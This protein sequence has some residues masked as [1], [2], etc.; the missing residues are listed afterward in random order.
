MT[1]AAGMGVS[2]CKAGPLDNQSS[3][4]AELSWTGAQLDLIEGWSCEK[5]HV[6]A[7]KLESQEAELAKFYASLVESEGHHSATYILMAREINDAETDRRLDFS[8]DL[9]AK[10]IRVPNPAAILH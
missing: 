6:L 2:M 7:R 8:L 4:K 5:F 9:E 1:L 10:P 3:C